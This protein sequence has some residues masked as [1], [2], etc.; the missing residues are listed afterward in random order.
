MADQREEEERVVCCIGD[1]H[2][3]ISK[4]QNLWTNLE[5]LIPSKSFKT[6]LIIFLGDYCD[7]G[8]DTRKLLDFLIS[9]PSK[10][11]SQTHVFLCGNHDLAFAAFLRVLPWPRDGSRF[12]DGWKEYEHNEEREGW[13]KGVGY[14]EMYLQGRRW[15]GLIKDRFNAAK[16]RNYQGSIYDAGLTFESY[17]VVHGSAGHVRKSGRVGASWVGAVG[18]AGTNHTTR[19]TGIKLTNAYFCDDGCVQDDVCIETSQGRKHCKLVAVH[20]GLDKAKGVAEQIRKL[21]EK[22]TSVPKVDALSG[23]ANVW[24]IPKVLIPLTLICTS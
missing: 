10:Y 5:T 24:E 8:P 13:F 2:G 17:G 15:G 11:P 16:G 7:R 12:C 4:L 22:D 1:L 14:E 23:R 20:A 9:L 6:S 21:K 19:V 3:Y 18:A